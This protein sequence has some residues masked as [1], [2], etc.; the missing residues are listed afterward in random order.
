MLGFAWEKVQQEIST[1]KMNKVIDELKHAPITTEAAARVKATLASE[2]ADYD[3]VATKRIAVV[4]YRG[5]AVP[6]PAQGLHEETMLRAAAV[7]NGIAV[8]LTYVE[9]AEFNARVAAAAAAELPKA[10]AAAT[11]SV[12]QACGAFRASVAT[13]IP[14]QD[15]VYVDK[16]AEAA[17]FSKSSTA[18]THP[19]IFAEA[20]AT[21]S[22]PAQVAALVSGIAN[23][24][25]ALSVALE[26]K[27]RGALVAI[28]AATTVVEVA[29]IVSSYKLTLTP[30]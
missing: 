16:A 28:D 13:A 29:N 7:V 30:S 9:I 6:T 15:T 14:F 4:H 3:G 22:T 19:Y 20:A 2:L 23:Q 27:R 10:K 24:W 5:V 1:E 12:N 8:A 21:G 26:A 25:K 18:E 17:T 11:E